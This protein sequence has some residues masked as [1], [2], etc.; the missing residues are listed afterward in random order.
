VKLA[1]KKRTSA[2]VGKTLAVPFGAVKTSLNSFKLLNHL[3]AESGFVTLVFAEEN[4]YF[5]C[6]FFFAS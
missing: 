6:L 4:F 5:L 1:L 2:V 3:A